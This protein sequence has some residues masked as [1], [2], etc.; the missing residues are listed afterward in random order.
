MRSDNL[1]KHMKKHEGENEDNIMTKGL[2]DVGTDD[3]IVNNGLD[4]GK[5]ENNVKNNQE[6]I[7]YTEE[8]YITLE[9]E[10]FADCKEFDRKI[11][12]G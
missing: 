1:K 7:R 4:D 6:K 9:K 5:I 3:N 12:L 10:V 8:Q 11:E 2:D